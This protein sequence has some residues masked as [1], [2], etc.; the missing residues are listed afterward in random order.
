MKMKK[1]TFSEYL[2]NQPN[3]LFVEMSK[4]AYFKWEDLYTPER[5]DLLFL[6][7]HGNKPMLKS[8]SLIPVA[9][10]SEMVYT[11]FNVKWNAIFDALAVD[12]PINQA[13]QLT[14]NEHI[15]SD[16][17]MRVL[18]EHLDKEGAFNSDDLIVGSGNES[19]VVTGDKVNR[20]RETTQTRIDNET[21]LKNMKFLEEKMFTDIVFKDISDL[22]N[23][24]I[25][26]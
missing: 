8:L 3:G 13:Y 15:T 20:Q 16:D 5:L 9:T 2:E 26:N 24:K 23:L 1:M 18:G 12:N 11:S 21:L 6:F 22:I 19:S 7:K 10:L 4:Y 25:Y 17:E 14:I